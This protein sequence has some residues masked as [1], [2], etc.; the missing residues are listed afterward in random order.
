[1]LK[2]SAPQKRMRRGSWCFDVV[3]VLDHRIIDHLG[4]F[5]SIT[6]ID[7]LTCWKR[8][9]GIWVLAVV[10]FIGHGGS[11][12][13]FGEFWIVMGWARGWDGMGGSCYLMRMP[14][15]QFYEAITCIVD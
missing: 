1:M 8:R 12:V 6:A 13:G 7:G 11:E 5:G 9:G 15:L 2:A 4:D 10:D 14:T 3:V